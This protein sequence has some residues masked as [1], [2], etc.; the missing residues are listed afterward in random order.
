MYSVILLM[1]ML[2]RYITFLLR[3]LSLILIEIQCLEHGCNYSIGFSAAIE[4]NCF[5]SQNNEKERKG[6]GQTHAVY[7]YC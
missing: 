3:N 6:D 2:I 7:C 4:N 1:L 5:F